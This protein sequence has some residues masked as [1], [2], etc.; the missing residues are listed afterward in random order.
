MKK[1]WIV[2]PLF[3]LLCWSGIT[4]KEPS[5]TDSQKVHINNDGTRKTA[6]E[7]QTG[8]IPTASIVNLELPKPKANDQII[9][10]TG[11]TLSYNSTYNIAN[12]V[13]YELTASETRPVVQRNN[14]F[15]PDPLLTSG[16]ASNEDYR[17]TGYDRGH[18]AP[19]ADMCYSNQT[20]V[21][22]WNRFIFQT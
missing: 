14:Q 13:A 20:M 7:V 21:E 12:W 4:Q 19:A 17:G 22:W 1:F 15:V 10:H 9:K 18:L 8:N 11:Y 3:I 16:K 5:A 2:L 6:S